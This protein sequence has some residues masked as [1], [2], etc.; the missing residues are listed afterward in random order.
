MTTR[1]VIKKCAAFG[2]ANSVEEAV[3][4]FGTTGQ[5]LADETLTDSPV[6]LIHSIDDI[7]EK[8]LY[9]RLGKPGTK[10]L[11]IPV[12]A[13]D[14]EVINACSTNLQNFLYDL[15]D[16]DDEEV[17]N[18]GRI[19]RELVAELS[20]IYPHLR[21]SS[22]KHRVLDI[23]SFNR[24]NVNELI[25]LSPFEYE[26][27]VVNVVV[28][29][30]LFADIEVSTDLS[31]PNTSTNHYRPDK[32]ALKNAALGHTTQL[33]AFSENKFAVIHTKKSAGCEN[34]TRN[35]NHDIIDTLAVNGVI[36]APETN[37]PLSIYLLMK[38]LETLKDFRICFI[39]PSYELKRMSSEYP[40]E[41]VLPAYRLNEGEILAVAY[42][43]LVLWFFGY[44]S[45]F[46]EGMLEYRYAI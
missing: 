40:C 30:Q 34:H 26:T 1:Y 7:T 24:V 41:Q 33:D 23:L 13:D 42:R 5:L 4:L 12:E 9:V 21:S 32:D 19:S 27:E 2:F 39:H 11:K 31:D 37:K 15:I 3:K 45:I 35:M 18:I 36:R 43:Y 29:D 8:V 38:K 6:K 20:E 17:A 44:C 16:I 28:N 10:D 25:K 22:L 46:T 14:T